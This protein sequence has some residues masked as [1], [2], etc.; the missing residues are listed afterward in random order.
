M[1]YEKINNLLQIHGQN[2]LIVF[3]KKKNKMT[4]E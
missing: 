3:H 2:F 4:Y 1:N